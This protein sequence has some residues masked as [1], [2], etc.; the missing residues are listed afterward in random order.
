MRA[1]KCVSI[2]IALFLA[3]GC[4]WIKASQKSSIKKTQYV[5]TGKIINAS[6]LEQGGTLLILPFS[7]GEGVEANEKLD[8]SALMVVRGILDILDEEESNYDA[9]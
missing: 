3:S 8:K 1:N 9:F 6:R 2:V 7:A 5:R 4:S